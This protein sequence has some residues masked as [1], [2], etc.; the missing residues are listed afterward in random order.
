MDIVLFERVDYF[1]LILYL[2]VARRQRRLR[3][4]TMS[5]YAFILLATALL[6]GA[7]GCK[8]DEETPIEPTDDDDAT[9]PEPEQPPYEDADGDGVP[10]LRDLCADT[11]EGEMH[12]ARGCS[13]YQASG[14]TMTIE[15]PEDGATVSGSD[16]TFTF[17]GDCE[18]YRLYASD[19]AAFPPHRR[20][21]LA[22]MISDGDVEVDV[23]DLPS[24]GDEGVVYWA[25]EG[26]A[27]GHTFLSEPRTLEVE[28]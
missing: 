9:A 4:S 17:D 25:V 22:D 8:D 13:S 3:S 16:V 2:Y 12:D 23:A 28:R 10:D 7:A 27:R 5:K 24:P 11:P 26:S 15:S 18:G 19:S 1:G 20:Q 14:C 6:L 21:L